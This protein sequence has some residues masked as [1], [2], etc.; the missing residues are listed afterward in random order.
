MTN[1]PNVDLQILPL[2]GET[3]LMADSFVVFGFS[4]ERKTSMLGNVVSAEGI[5]QPLQ[6]RGAGYIFFRLFFHAFVAASLSPDDSRERILQTWQRLW[7]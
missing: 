5:E 1:L 3:A 2:E 7:A 6:R 4:S